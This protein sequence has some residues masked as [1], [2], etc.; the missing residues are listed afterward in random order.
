M[1]L[2]ALAVVVLWGR[3]LLRVHPLLTQPFGKLL[4]FPH[5]SSPLLEAGSV[6]VLPWVALCDRAS[7]LVARALFP[8]PAL[9]PRIKALQTVFEG[10]ED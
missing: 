8:E 7:L 10:R 1:A 9:E 5:R 4:L 3:P 2:I 6:T